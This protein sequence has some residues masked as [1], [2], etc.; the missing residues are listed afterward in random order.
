MSLNDYSL[1]HGGRGYGRFVEYGQPQ[2]QSYSDGQPQT[3]QYGPERSTTKLPPLNPTD[4]ITSSP[5]TANSNRIP[6]ISSF[7]GSAAQPSYLS[8]QTSNTM[9]LR[10]P[11]D[12]NI[13][14]A[15]SHFGTT[16]Q[17]Q[18]YPTSESRSREASY[19]L[20]DTQRVQ[21][22]GSRK[23]QSSAPS[24]RSNTKY[25]DNEHT[26]S[27]HNFPAGITTSMQ[28]SPPPS[29]MR[30]KS[31]LGEDTRPKKDRDLTALLTALVRT[32]QCHPNSNCQA[33]PNAFVITQVIQ[34]NSH[35]TEEMPPDFDMECRLPGC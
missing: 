3:Y 34:D 35:A 15:R 32:H 8:T 14:A 18:H 9:S 10:S 23:Y 30:K 1:T 16:S 13:P 11:A 17:S 20:S 31:S 26:N 29:H 6:P 2:R 24:Q 5:R 22:S 19:P 12:F 27:M 7:L 21:E 28:F 4:S 25:R 33:I